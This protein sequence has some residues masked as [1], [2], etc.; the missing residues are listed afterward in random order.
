MLW[1]KTC[2]A[3]PV[4]ALITGGAVLI[5]AV[6]GQALFWIS[7]LRLP[8]ASSLQIGNGL[9]FFASDGVYYF[10]LANA[11]APAGLRSVLQ[12]SR[13][14]SSVFFQQVFGLFIWLF[15]AMPSVGLLLNIFAVIGTMALI[16]VWA[17]HYAVPWQTTALPLLAVGYTPS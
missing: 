10:M 11:R 14:E 3:P 7:Y 8:V 17:H 9:W 16:V 6:A 2:G 4:I 12:I 1:R 5:R 13:K 15:G